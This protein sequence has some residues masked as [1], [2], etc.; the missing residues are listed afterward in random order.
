M[1]VELQQGEKKKQIKILHTISNQDSDFYWVIIAI[2]F[3]INA[4]IIYTIRQEW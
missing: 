4:G 2:I 1:Q 3:T